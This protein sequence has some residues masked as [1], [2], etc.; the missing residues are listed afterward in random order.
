MANAAFAKP[1]IDEALE[2]ATFPS[3]CLVKMHC[4][5]PHTLSLAVK[6]EVVKSEPQEA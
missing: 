1:E 4:R 5:I 3:H 6:S 2:A